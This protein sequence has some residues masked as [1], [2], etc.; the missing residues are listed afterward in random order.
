MTIFSGAFMLFNG[1]PL[2]CEDVVVNSR[3][4]INPRLAHQEQL[5]AEK[6]G[7]SSQQPNTAVFLQPH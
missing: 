4:E 6:L 1:A 3:T 2:L 7:N 5:K